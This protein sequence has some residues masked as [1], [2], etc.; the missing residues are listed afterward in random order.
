MIDDTFL[1]ETGIAMNLQL[2]SAGT[3]L[4]AV[5]AGTG[6]DLSLSNAS[7]DPVNYAIRGAVM[8]LSGFDGFDEVAGRFHPS[9]MVR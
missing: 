6:P 5:L 1:P 4:P 7:T 8:D 3:L 9:A 2:V